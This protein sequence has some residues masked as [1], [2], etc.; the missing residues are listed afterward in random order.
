[1]IQLDERMAQR[2]SRSEEARDK[3]VGLAR[4]IINQIA[5]LYSEKILSDH[6][7]RVRQATNDLLDDFVAGLILRET[8]QEV[9]GFAARERMAEVA[10]EFY[11]D[12]NAG[13]MAHDFRGGYHQGYID[14]MR[15]IVKEPSD[16]DSRV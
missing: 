9:P 10:W 14:G 5:D 13:E 15:A 11:F 3:A 2:R 6:W 12:R 4:N 1:M 16:D 7:A 8:A